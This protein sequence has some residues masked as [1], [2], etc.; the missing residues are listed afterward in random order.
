MRLL[1]AGG[2]T[3]GHLYPALAV[4]RAFRADEPG[5]AVLLVGRK[6]GPEERAVPA[7]GFD[8]ETVRLR[9]LDR[10][11]PW[12]NL[13]LPALIPLA[14]RSALHLVDRFRPDVVLGMGGYVMAP[15]VA[16]AR[17]R[18]IPYVLHEKDVR[19][20]LA[21]RYFAVNAAAICTTLPGTDKRLPN[22]RVFQ[23]GVPLREGFEPRTPEVPP[24]R[25]LITGGSQGARRLNQV[26]WSALDG[27]CER[28]E[29]VVHVAGEQGAEGLTRYAR[30]R[31][32]GIA[33]TDEMAALMARADLMGAGGAGVSALAR[34]FLARGDEV[35]GC[36]VKESDTTAELEEAGVKIARGHD[37]EHVLGKDLLVYSGAIKKSPE[38]DA[39]RAM[40]LKV[41]SRAEMLAQLINETDSIAVAGTAGKTTVTH[42]VGH[43]LVSAGYDPTVLVGDG[44]SARAGRSDWLVA[45]TDESDGTL[46]L[47][48]PQRAIV[49]NIE[50]DHPDQFRDVSAVRDLFQWFIEGLPRSGLA[51]LCA[52]DE[53]ARELSPKARKITYGFRQGATY[54]CEPVRPFPIY[55]GVDLL[56]HINLRQPGRHNIQNATAAAAMALELGIGFDDVAA[57]LRTFPGAHRRMEFL[58]VFQGAAVYDDYAH[59]P[60]KVRATIQAAREL[61]HRRL[62]VVFQ[63]HRYSRL[64]ALMHDFAR[65]FVGADRVYVL[66]VYS[67]GEDN[68]SGVRASDLAHQIPNGIYVGDFTKAKEAL[69][70]IVGPDDLVLLMGAGDIKKLGDDLAHKI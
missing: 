35:T 36:D 57:A 11:A 38:L 37:P 7:A 4:A 13:A 59:H 52:D 8:L 51:V 44:A 64:N 42:M 27:L 5:G 69:E 29:E 63:P 60:T 55:R 58:G 26:V 67:A 40:G 32:R 33:F 24:R 53:L 1:I 49:T 15:A 50:L 65:A 45:E 54:R 14:L 48:H 10:D 47:H 16:A 19:P 39:A 20:G 46:T 2:G 68:V 66:D 41:L 30:D 70:E 17:M 22:G 56:G 18:R 25:L 62:V 3:G 9:G 34:V 43:I 23:T 21:T 6:G 28:F 12:K 61:R 31:Y